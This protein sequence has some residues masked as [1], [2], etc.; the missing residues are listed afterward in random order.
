MQ[1]L[2]TSVPMYLLLLQE[3]SEKELEPETYAL[4]EWRSIHYGS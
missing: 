1:A 3:W 2:A 4:S